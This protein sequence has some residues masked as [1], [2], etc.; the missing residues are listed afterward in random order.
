MSSIPGALLHHA[1]AELALKLDRQVACK[2]LRVEGGCW[3]NTSWCCWCRRDGVRARGTI[4]VGSS[5][6]QV[7]PDK[8]SWPLGSPLGAGRPQWRD[9]LDCLWFYWRYAAAG[10]GMARNGVSEGTENLQGKKGRG[11]E[12]TGC[13]LSSPISR[14][15][16]GLQC[17]SGQRCCADIPRPGAVC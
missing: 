17:W 6:H 9:C 11:R 15:V 10:R 14:W 5:W 8:L 13:P 2:M 4:F 1:S 7:P 16:W 12:P 3:K